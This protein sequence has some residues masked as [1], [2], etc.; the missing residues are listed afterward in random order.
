MAAL[1]IIL[2]FPL[3]LEI[4]WGTVL[5]TSAIATATAAI[6]WGGATLTHKINQRRHEWV[7]AAYTGST[8][9]S[10]VSTPAA[11]GTLQDTFARDRN[12]APADTREKAIE[13]GWEDITH[14]KAAAK[15]N[16]RLRD[17]E[18]GDIWRFDR[19]QPGKHGH[20]RRDHWHHENPNGTNRHNELLDRNG[21]PCGRHSEDSEESHLY[22][23]GG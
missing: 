6:A 1:F 7:P 20:Q 15:G 4:S 18:T 3:A 10:Y 9:T 23:Q 11:E 22:W 8:S 16:Y 14:P 5:T 19:G 17:P 2:V 13:Q 12:E 21:N